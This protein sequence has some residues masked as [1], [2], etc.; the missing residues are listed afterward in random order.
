M[1]EELKNNRRMF[2]VFL[3][4]MVLRFGYEGFCYYPYLDDY[5][6]YFYYPSLPSG[7][8]LTGSGGTIFTR[9][10][11]SLADI[12]VWGNFADFLWA[13]MLILAVLYGIS[14]ILFYCAMRVSGIKL[15]PFF[16]I[17][18]GFLPVN[19]EGTYWISA[20][21]RI[22]V[23]LFLIA[24]SAAF[25]AEHIQRGRK[26]DFA[27]FAVFHFLSYW[28]YEQTAAV[29]F[30]LCFWLCIRDKKYRAAAVPLLCG[31]AFAL[32]YMTLGKLGNNAARLETVGI[33]ELPR[34]I[35]KALAQVFYILT[36]VSGK[37]LFIG[38]A[39]GLEKIIAAP[40]WIFIILL[41]G[42]LWG[43]CA[44]SG[45]RPKAEQA[46]LGLFLFFAA[47]SPFYVSRNMWFNL[48]NIVPALLGLS[49]VLD[50]FAAKIPK[51]AA[52]IIGGALVC[53]C[54]VATVS[55][56]ADYNAA[57]RHDYAVSS[58]LAKEHKKTGS[59]RLTLSRKLPYYLPQNAI[60]HDH[61]VTGAA[62]DW[63]Y[64]GM[65]RGLTKTP[66]IEVVQSEGNAE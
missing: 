55:E 14:G 61:I 13:A 65:V 15:S 43:F 58:E 60:Y 28:F 22:A 24:L 39:R 56:V 11:S 54:L 7:R 35:I 23:S 41:L 3:L 33:F 46:L 30:C 9:P 1:A 59:L 2:G 8:V 17:I 66:G 44:K 26:R 10:L 4:G 20:S 40:E 53:L 63:G 36:G 38:A 29:S 51:P 12:F 49:M 16:L 34:N 27:L 37:I 62:L 32:W 47:F 19:T 25:L 5:V 50:F 18:Y 42:G 52:R 6:Q 57:A 64:T 45:G 48:R 21:S 31:A